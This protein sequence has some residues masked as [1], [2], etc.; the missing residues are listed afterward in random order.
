VIAPY[1][2][3]G[4]GPKWKF[5]SGIALS[6]A[7]PLRTSPEG[8]IIYEAKF[9]AQNTLALAKALSLTCRQTYMEVVNST[10]LYQLHRFQFFYPRTLVRFLSIIPKESRNAI[11][12]IRLA[13]PW[14]GKGCYH[15]VISPEALS[16]LCTCI[17]LRK[18]SLVI[19]TSTGNRNCG[20]ADYTHGGRDAIRAVEVLATRLADCG[21]MGLEKFDVLLWDP[22]P[23]QRETPGAVIVGSGIWTDD[24]KMSWA[25]RHMIPVIRPPGHYI[26]PLDDCW[27]NATK[28]KLE[29]LVEKLRVQV[30]RPREIMAV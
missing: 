22:W 27:D 24:A 11:Q 19:G 2:S 23:W 26:G 6:P 16:A 17:G 20:E 21:L 9:L 18:L 29:M 3:K 28:G 5:Q 15:H 30:T 25:T 4:S 8:K 1:E 10:L 12:D 13:F 14:A 7:N